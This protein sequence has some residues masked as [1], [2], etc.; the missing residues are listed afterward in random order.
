M[1]LKVQNFFFNLS[2][3]L[4]FKVSAIVATTLN[5][6]SLLLNSAFENANSILIQTSK[7]SY[8]KRSQQLPKHHV[9]NL[10]KPYL[11]PP[12]LSINLNQDDITRKSKT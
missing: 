9:S 4:M 6:F 7:K 1:F 2:C 5:Y 10:Q 3:G 12:P 11:I 8:F